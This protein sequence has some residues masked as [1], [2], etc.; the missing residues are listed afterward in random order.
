MNEILFKYKENYAMNTR[1]V[2]KFYFDVNIKNKKE[3]K[4]ILAYI[5]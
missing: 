1:I 2:T 5:K 4:N 3:I